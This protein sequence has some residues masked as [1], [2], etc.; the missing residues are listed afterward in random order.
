MDSASSIAL[1]GMRAAELRLNVAANN[2]ANVSMVPSADAPADAPAV[3][4]NAFQPL[5]ADQT[6][7]AGGETAVTVRVQFP[8]GALGGVDLPSEAVQVVTARY[9]FAAS[10]AVMRSSAQLQQV[11]LDT[12]A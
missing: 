3:A 6:D 11:L 7:A 2:I 9:T 4:V 10:V 5:H 12:F 8:N 1:S